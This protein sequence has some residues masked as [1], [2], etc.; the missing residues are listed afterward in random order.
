MNELEIKSVNKTETKKLKIIKNDEKQI[1]KSITKSLSSD[2]LDYFA[3]TIDQ[4]FGLS[5]VKPS[6]LIIKTVASIRDR[7]LLKKTICFFRKLKSEQITSKEFEK[8]RNKIN[9]DKKFNKERERVLIVIDK[10]TEIQKMKYLAK[11]FAAFIKETISVD[12]FEDYVE[13]LGRMYLRDINV[14][15]KV[16]KEK[17]LEDTDFD[18]GYIVEIPLEEKEQIRAFNRLN[19]QGIVEKGQGINWNAGEI[20]EGNQFIIKEYGKDFINYAL[21]DNTSVLRE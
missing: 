10:E 4:M 14:L 5:I 16:Y 12:I 15:M 11:L 21:K 17:N 9:T 20:D 2:I 3:D 1:V 7:D 18:N 13:A 19:S 8:Y 6:K